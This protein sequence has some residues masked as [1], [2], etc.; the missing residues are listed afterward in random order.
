VLY[1]SPNT[2]TVAGVAE[3][4]RLV[5]KLLENNWKIKKGCDRIIVNRLLRS[6][7]KNVK[8]QNTEVWTWSLQQP[9][10]KTNPVKVRIKLNAEWM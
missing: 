7:H 3:F 10:F 9:N 8:Y 6:G 1:P 5:Y 2:V 4:R